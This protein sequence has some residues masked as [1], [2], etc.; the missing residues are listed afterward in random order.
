MPRNEL[1]SHSFDPETLRALCA[2]IDD[3]I[4]VLG[5]KIDSSNRQR[6]H[7]A[8]AVAVID[9]AKTGQRDPV[10]LGR[11]AMD[12]DRQALSIVASCKP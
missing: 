7:E 12:K 8:I 6:V 5:A 4:T 2:A 10:R 3:A 1:A 11:Y 9:L